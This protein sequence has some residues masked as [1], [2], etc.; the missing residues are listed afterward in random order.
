MRKLS[1]LLYLLIIATMLLVSGCE[2]VTSPNQET[3]T[4]V[5]SSEIA[6]ANNHAGNTV[7][8]D[9]GNISGTEDGSQANPYDTIQE[10]VDHADDNDVV[11]LQS[12]FTLSSQVTINEPLTLDGN[13]NT[14]FASFSKTSNSNNSAI[15]VQ[16]ASN[17]NITNLTIEGE[18]GTALTGINVYE[19]ISVLVSDVSIYNNDHTG[20]LVNGSEVTAHN[21]ST[22]GHGWH[23]INVDLGSGV[24]SPATLTV[25]GISSH[26]ENSPLP[27]DNFVDGVSVPDIFVDDNSKAVMVN[28]VNNQYLSAAVD[29]RGGNADVYTHHLPETKDDCKKSGWKNYKDYKNQGDCIQFVNTG[30]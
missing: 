3:G 27:I 15:G 28:D 23:G 19:S 2:K 29:F 20:L 1:N 8:V 5:V 10:G 9:A 16:G 18:D 11:L 12:D 21:I 4:D 26:S 17:V 7:Y 24:V 13:G 6:T 30:K 22:A 14:I 25:T